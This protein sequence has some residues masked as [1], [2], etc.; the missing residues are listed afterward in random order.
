[1][2][3]LAGPAPSGPLPHRPSPSPLPSFPPRIFF[4]SNPSLFVHVQG[5]R[6]SAPSRP[7]VGSAP[8]LVPRSSS[9]CRPSLRPAGRRRSSPSSFE[10]AGA[11]PLFP[12]TAASTTASA[13]TPPSPSA[14]SAVVLSDAASPIGSAGLLCFTRRRPKRH[15]R[16]RLI[17]QLPALQVP[18]KPLHPAALLCSVP[19]LARQ[20]VAAPRPRRRKSHRRC[21][22]ASRLVLCIEPSH[23]HQ[24]PALTSLSTASNRP[25]LPRHGDERASAWAASMQQ[26]SAQPPTD[27]GQAR[28][29]G[30]VSE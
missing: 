23:D 11:A 17:I 12:L 15:H 1:M 19:G 3:L 28:C 26:A 16:S 13:W 30:C 7:V 6:S 22:P 10:M 29:S 9:R 14:K 8:S 27:L 5:A 20:A 21:S 2:L 18:D 24:P 4:L 25:H